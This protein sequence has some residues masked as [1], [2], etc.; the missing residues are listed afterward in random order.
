MPNVIDA[1]ANVI[2]RVS[3][4][5]NL[6][7]KYEAVA[8]ATGE[9]LDEV[10]A[11]GLQNALDFVGRMCYMIDQAGDKEIRRMLGGKIDGQAKLLD[12][13]GR[14]LTVHVGGIKV[15]LRTSVQEQI[16]WALRSMGKEG[17]QKAAGELIA[18]AVAEKFRS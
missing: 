15:E 11:R 10:C 4:P 18:Q 9:T 5:T 8:S 3:L 6:V 1:S 12:M 17:D 14:L 7:E 13:I 16:H 2:L